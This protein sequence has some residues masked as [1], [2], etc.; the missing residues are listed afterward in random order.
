MHPV[1]WVRGD[2]YNRIFAVQTVDHEPR[3]DYAVWNHLFAALP[4]EYKL[5]DSTVLAY[6]INE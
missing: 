5:P 1:F 4:K 6:V 3:V 2:L